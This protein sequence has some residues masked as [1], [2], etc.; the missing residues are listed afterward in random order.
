MSRIGEQ[1]LEAWT[2][3]Y[4]FARH[5]KGGTYRVLRIAFAEADL[6]IQVVYENGEGLVFT[7]PLDDFES[8]VFT[9]ISLKRFVAIDVVPTD[10]QSV[11]W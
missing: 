3:A 9:D 4:T 5:Y 8:Y 11:S 10:W 1:Q 2:S 6:E 7:R